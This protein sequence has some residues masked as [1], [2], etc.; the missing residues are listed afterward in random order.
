MSTTKSVETHEFQAEVSR[1][2]HM[3]VRSVYSDTE[4]FL[5]ELI[6]NASDAC[7]R[8]RYAALTDDSLMDG[9][10]DFRI[11]VALDAANRTIRI[12]D[13]G[14]G[15][16]RDDLIA[17]LGTIARSGTAAFMEQLTGDAQKDVS[18]I[19]QFGVGFYSAFMV[20]DHVDVV[21]RKAGT[22]EAFKWSSDGQGGY[23]IEAATREG[24]GTDITLHVRDSE[25]EN[26]FLDVNRLRHIVTTYSDHIA[27]PIHLVEVK[28]DAVDEEEAVN[29][30]SA[31]WARNKSD[32]T[33]EQYAEFYRHVGHAFDAPALTLHY[34]AE[35]MIEYSAVLFVPETPPMDLFDPARKPRVKLYVKR[36]FITD[37]TGELIP[38]YLR[39]LRGVIDSEDLPLNISREMLQNNP[40]VAR[41]R[42]AVTGKVLSA[43][44]E[45]AENEPETFD[46]IW[47]AFGPVIKEGL[48]EDAERREAL[49]SLTRFRSTAQEGWTS[50]ADY[51]SRMKDGQEAIY[52]VTAANA[53]AARNSPHLEGF[54]SRGVEVL[55]LGDP[56]DDFWLSMVEGF[57]DKPFKSVTQGGADLAALGQDEAAPEG[58]AAET[59]ALVAALK[60]SLG[61]Q[62]ADVRPTDRLTDSPVCLV[63][64]DGD[65]DLNLERILRQ[66]Q[67]LDAARPRVLEI[68]P[69]HALIA[70]M[71]NRAK[72]SGAL[73]ALK[74]PAQLL[75]DQAKLLEGELPPDPAAFA[76]RLA[77]VM[78][79][80]IS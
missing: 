50:L 51:V 21:S 65:I 10:G 63:A 52:Y 66:N 57:E 44:E 33:D 67:Q 8:L 60:E 35:G 72:T 14:I 1:L 46:K 64:E 22:E 3:M 25:T 24:R 26:A 23:T 80:A 19:G 77:S 69:R 9:E 43:L 5:R 16:D 58:E 28:E 70:A 59:D 30:G 55:L 40:V 79:Q 11:T 34:R 68:N 48:Y 32:V 36:V 45:K 17:H 4:I 76:K 54:K 56:V 74:E 29:K 2:L 6:S 42:K 47:D 27:F 75:L 18:L 53:D 13:N 78:T 12:S 15:M 62:V 31:L 37:D 61:D 20:A 73:D 49:L 41:I 39:F 38:G 71:A 7:D